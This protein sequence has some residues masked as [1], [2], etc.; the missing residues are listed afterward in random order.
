MTSRK[1]DWVSKHDT[2]SLAYPFTSPT[3]DTARTWRLG[4]VLDQ[5]EEGS[6]VGH[7]WT[8]ELI[9]SPRPFKVS[10]EVGHE[11]AVRLYEDARRNFDE[12]PGEDYEGT[13][14]LAGA[15]AVQTYGGFIGG[16]RWCFNIDAVRDAVLTEGPVVIGIPWLET[17]TEVPYN[18]LLNVGG[19]EVGGHCLLVYGYHP[20]LKVHG[21]DD[22]VRCFRLRNSWG[23]SWGRNG[24][25][26]IRYE[27]LQSL[28]RH[29][30]EACVPMNRKRV[31]F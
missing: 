29:T 14:V 12:W 15:K 28:L 8:A 11:Y 26:L 9:A 10:P 20:G 19:E 27:D 6:C 22:P 3:A 5:G 30:G 25:A 31:L 18:R 16:Y 21:E 13:S 24:N 4:A 1:L 17:M 7:G 23:T 2:R